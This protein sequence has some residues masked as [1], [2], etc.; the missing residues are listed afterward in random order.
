MQRLLARSPDA[1]PLNARVLERALTQTFDTDLAR[2][3]QRVLLTLS[4]SRAWL[5]GGASAETAPTRELC[6]RS[7]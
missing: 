4:E 6:A 2:A 1:R 7:G 5:G 3:E